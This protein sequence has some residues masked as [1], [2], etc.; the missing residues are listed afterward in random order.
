MEDKR[1]H[2]RLGTAGARGELCDGAHPQ[3]TPPRPPNHAWQR[4]SRCADIERLTARQA[5]IA[6]LIQSGV[7]ET[8]EAALRLLEA[9][10]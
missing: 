9:R 7:V 8:P 2:P 6:A 10:P 4:W 5:F 3:Y 1:E